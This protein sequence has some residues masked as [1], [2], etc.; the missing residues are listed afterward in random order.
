MFVERSG[1]GR[2]SL[3]AS[4]KI[5]SHGRHLMPIPWN[6]SLPR[7]GIRIYLTRPM[8]ARHPLTAQPGARIHLSRRLG[9][10][11]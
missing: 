7:H 2:S 6:Q 5:G 9:G 3:G 11:M 10:A 1:H 4:C 8:D